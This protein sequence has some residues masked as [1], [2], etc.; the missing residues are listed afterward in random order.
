MKNVMVCTDTAAADI[1]TRDQS[2]RTE[3][4]GNGEGILYIALNFPISFSADRHHHMP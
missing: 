3:S 2:P 1:S 4:N